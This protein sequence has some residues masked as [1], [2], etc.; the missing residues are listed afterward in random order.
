MTSLPVPSPG[1]A[2]ATAFVVEHLG[3]VV[4]G[5]V[6]PSLRF[7][8][9][10]SKADAALAAFDVAGYAANRNEVYPQPRRGAS[11]LSPYIRHGLLPLRQVWDHVGGGPARDVKKYRDELLWQEYARHWY[12]R[13]GRSTRRGVRHSLPASAG[14]DGWDRDM[15]CIELP[16]DEG[17]D[18]AVRYRLVA[19]DPVIEPRLQRRENGGRRPEVHIRHA[20]S[21]KAIAARAQDPGVHF[22]RR[23]RAPVYILIK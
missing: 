14:V 13:L 18:Q 2:E 22:E 10:Q 16:L 8:G 1:Q 23:D 6:H 20:R 9:G 12:A 19:E 15:A 17:G 4:D 3:H 21:E 11:G 7:E 5:D